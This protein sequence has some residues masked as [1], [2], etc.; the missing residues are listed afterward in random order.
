[1]VTTTFG[2]GEVAMIG[3]YFAQH[4]APVAS[5]P[6]S[7]VNVSVGG[8]VPDSVALLPPP[9]DLVSHV[10]DPTSCTSCRVECRDRRRPDQYC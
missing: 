7:S 2:S 1:V 4:G 6:T 8:T 3:A 9:Y 10:S 5:I